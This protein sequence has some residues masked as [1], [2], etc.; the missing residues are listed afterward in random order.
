[1]AVASKPTKEAMA[2]INA[3]PGEPP[4]N[5][6]GVNDTAST[7]CAPPRSSTAAENTR[8]IPIS[9]TS[10]TPSTFAPSSMLR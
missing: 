2:N 9:T 1:M 3:M 10:S 8:M 6:D 7:P 4:R 5:A